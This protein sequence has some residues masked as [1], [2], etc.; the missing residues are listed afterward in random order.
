MLELGIDV[1]TELKKKEIF[2][3]TRMPASLPQ[4]TPVQRTSGPRHQHIRM[5]SGSSSSI[6]HKNSNLSNHSPQ[7]QPTASSQSS[8]TSM[9]S[10][11]FGVQGGMNPPQAGF[12]A[13]ARPQQHTLQHQPKSPS[14]PSTVSV[15]TSQAGLQ[16]IAP[17]PNGL[18][19]RQRPSHWPSPYQTHI[20]QLGKL[21]SLHSCVHRFLNLA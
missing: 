21:P 18:M 11:M 5:S 15:P 19:G 4:P 17:H 7:L 6:L 9:I 13:Q 20:E 2:P 14:Y 10:P 8:P 16:S 12:Q 3:S 1:Q